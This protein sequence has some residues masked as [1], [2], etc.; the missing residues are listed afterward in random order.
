MDECFVFVM[1]M[2]WGTDI[3]KIQLLFCRLLSSDYWRDFLN[4]KRNLNDE[5]VA[6]CRRSWRMTDTQMH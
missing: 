4:E 6:T 1:F 2:S 5:K 3:E